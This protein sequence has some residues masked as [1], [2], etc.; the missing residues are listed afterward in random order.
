MVFFFYVVLLIIASL[1]GELFDD[2]PGVEKICQIL[3]VIIVFDGFFIKALKRAQ[4][5]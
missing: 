5:S 1:V 4:N 3:C 2:N